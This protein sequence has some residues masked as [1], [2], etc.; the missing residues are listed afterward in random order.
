MLTDLNLANP[1]DF[2]T[3]FYGHRS[4]IPVMQEDKHTVVMQGDWMH[5]KKLQIFYD[6][7]SQ[8]RHSIT[9]DVR[10][11]AGKKEAN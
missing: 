8:Y 9:P 4:R 6:Y 1:D 11:F 10:S 5:R 7:C 3:G 2:K